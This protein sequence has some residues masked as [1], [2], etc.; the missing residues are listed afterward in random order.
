MVYEEGCQRV[1]TSEI[2]SVND[3]VTV[4]STIYEIVCQLNQYRSVNDYDLGLSMVSTLK[5][6]LSTGKKFK[7]STLCARSPMTVYGQRNMKS[8]IVSME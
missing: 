2:V 7:P 1:V 5:L 6:S 4:L 3:F 8:A